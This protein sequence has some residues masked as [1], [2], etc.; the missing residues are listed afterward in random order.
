MDTSGLNK[1]ALCDW[2]GDVSSFFYPQMFSFLLQCN[3]RLLELVHWCVKRLAAVSGQL[4]APLQSS[5]I[6]YNCFKEYITSFPE[7]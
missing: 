3:E 6:V 2:Q 5:H 7:L 4:D 1:L